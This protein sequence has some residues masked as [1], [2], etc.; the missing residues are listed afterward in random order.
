MMVLVVGEIP[1]VA[2]QDLPTMLD[3]A[4]GTLQC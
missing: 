4:H 3:G 1:C 2:M